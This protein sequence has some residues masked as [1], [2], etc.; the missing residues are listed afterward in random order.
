[1]ILESLDIDWSKIHIARVN[2]ICIYFFGI[3]GIEIFSWSLVYYECSILTHIL[4]GMGWIVS[5]QC[6]IIYRGKHGTV[7]LILGKMWLNNKE[8]ECIRYHKYNSSH[9]A[10]K[11]LAAQVELSTHLYVPLFWGQTDCIC[12]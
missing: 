2:H 4:A 8:H 7:F 12:C 3:T 11:C 1:M 6:G 10:R 9:N 5:E